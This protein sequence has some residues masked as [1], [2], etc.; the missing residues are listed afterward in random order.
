M[1]NPMKKNT[2]QTKA[3]NTGLVAQ[4]KEQ[5]KTLTTRIESLE[6][7]I[8]TNRKDRIIREYQNE[9]A[10]SDLRH[11]IQAVQ[12]KVNKADSYIRMLYKIDPKLMDINTNPF[13]ED[14]EFPF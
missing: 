4:Y 9:E 3:R 5:I 6:Q 14:E 8:E 13:I 1:N 12:C 7:T 11:Q 2:S 10:M